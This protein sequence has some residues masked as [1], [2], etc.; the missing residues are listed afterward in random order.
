M[1]QPRKDTIQVINLQSVH[2]VQWG[3]GGGG[4]SGPSHYIATKFTACLH[5]LCTLL[6]AANMPW[7]TD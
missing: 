3:G 4:G 5:V 2:D 7:H 6:Y 1:Q